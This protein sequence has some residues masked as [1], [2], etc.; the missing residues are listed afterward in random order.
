MCVSVLS[1]F[2]CVQ[3]LGTLWTVADQAP[4]SMGCSKQEYW[5]GVPCPS[6]R[7]LP[8]PRIE[9]Q[10]L[11]S[12]ALA[13]GFFG[14]T[15]EARERIQPLSNARNPRRRAEGPDTPM[16]F[17]APF[18]TGQFCSQEET[19]LSREVC[20]LSTPL[21]Q[22]EHCPP[23]GGHG[24]RRLT[25]PNDKASTFIGQEHLV[26]VIILLVGLEQAAL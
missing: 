10:S 4:L 8:N 19:S 24:T 7:D 6:P 2:S 20:A 17:S 23:R 18:P 16:R 9:S 5:N 14:T 3:L 12:P 13:G 22:W 11:T 15:W 25:P 26:R 1:C 21:W